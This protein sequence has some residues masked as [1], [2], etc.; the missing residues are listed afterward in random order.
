MSLQALL[1]SSPAYWRRTNLPLYVPGQIGAPFCFAPTVLLTSSANSGAREVAEEVVAAELSSL[2][3]IMTVDVE[4]HPRWELLEGFDPIPGSNVKFILYL[5]KDTFV[6]DERLADQVRIARAI[7]V[8]V[9]MAHENDPDLGGCEFGKFFET[10][11]EELI[12][13]GLYR[14]LAILLFPGRHREA[15]IISL[16]TRLGGMPVAS[17]VPRV[18]GDVIERKL[19]EWRYYGGGDLE[20][21]LASGAVALIDASWIVE[22]AETGGVLSHRQA[23]PPEAF[24]SLADLVDATEGIAGL[25]IFA[26]SYP[27]LH[28]D[29]PD[30]KGANLLRVAK[31]L[32]ALLNCYPRGQRYG[33]FWD[34][35][36]LHQ[37]PDPANGVVRTAA[38][39]ALFKQ[40]LGCLGTLYSH[41]NTT[42]LRLTSFP[43]GYS[44]EAYNLPEGANV[45][46][47]PDRGW[48]CTESAWASL[49]KASGL[50][51]NLG[52][53]RHA[54]SRRALIEECTQGGGRR[55]PM[56]PSVFAAE[57]ESKSFTN[58]K[59]DKPLVSRLYEGAF[60]E[61]F[62]KVTKL[63]YSCL[64]WG[65]AEAAQLAGVLA[66][67]VAQ[68]LET[69]ALEGNPVSGAGLDA[70]AAAICRKRATPR[71]KSIRVDASIPRSSRLTLRAACKERGIK[72]LLVST[73]G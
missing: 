39:N 32:K 15:S 16:A 49:T 71:L 34:Y 57:L 18:A 56:L 45:A 62:A 21:V 73:Q 2:V 14:D 13:D 59:D 26:L 24:L 9:V 38:Q 3:P 53:M 11:P 28:P 22:F 25:P 67:G 55:P 41:P 27:W 10:T 4:S 69:L 51:L 30:P 29:H 20:P 19:H 68:Q 5:N 8:P 43:D 48:C 40:G 52:L 23:L 54:G 50:S 63:D 33:L 61:Q 44:R 37:H 17:H 66:S 35:G 6:S 65:D 64:G 12:L 36:S 70:L 7:G 42:V 31:A 46:A 58:G 47:Y 60:K 1:L 72:L